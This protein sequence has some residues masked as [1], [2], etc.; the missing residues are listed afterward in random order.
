M[1]GYYVDARGV[2]ANLNNLAKNMPKGCEEALEKAVKAGIRSARYNVPKDTHKLKESIKEGN[3]V[4]IGGKMY[5]ASFKAYAE[6]TSGKDY[7]R[8]QESGWT[9]KANR[10]HEG[11]FYMLKARKKAEKV[12]VT[13]SNKIIGKYVRKK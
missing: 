9:D 8:Y 4:K 5:S 1:S 2:R 13:E 7:A 10:F 12:F 6:N 3:R 11:K